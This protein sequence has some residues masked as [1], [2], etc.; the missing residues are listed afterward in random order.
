MAEGWFVTGTDTGVGK[1]RAAAGLLRAWQRRGVIAAGMKPV[2]SGCVPT[3]AGL[4]S[5][6]AQALCDAAGVRARYEDINPYAFEPAIAPHIAA[7]QAGVTI[8]FDLIRI[9]YDRLAHGADRVIVE[10][11]GGWRV[12][13]GDTTL[14]SD[15]VRHL[16][17]AV[18][19]VVG[20]RLGCLNHALLTAEAI[21][22]TDHRRLIGW[23]GSTLDPT[24]PC[25][26]ENIA[27]LRARLPAHCL[28]ILP[29]EPLARP[30]TVADALDLGA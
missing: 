14:Q 8:D 23:I 21:T 18:V 16:D 5:E 24:L 26:G 2:A 25:L 7:R 28:G 30:D 19:L 9:A 12:P 29:H 4:R 17:L 3:T 27:T 10:G 15:L 22:A 1:T 20:L 13:L 11:A 6:D